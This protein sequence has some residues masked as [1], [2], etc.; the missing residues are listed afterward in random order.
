M[1]GDEYF[2]RVYHDE[3]L[4]WYAQ[5]VYHDYRANF[6]KKILD[7]FTDSHSKMCR[8]TC[9]LVKSDPQIRKETCERDVLTLTDASVHGL[10]VW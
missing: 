7:R 9:K 10:E 4:T 6:R 5:R 2:D 8:V 3:C 1:L